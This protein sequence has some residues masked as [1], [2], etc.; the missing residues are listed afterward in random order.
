M[1]RGKSNTAYHFKIVKFD[2]N[3][4]IVAEIYFKTA[5]EIALELKVSRNTI[6]LHLKTP[7]R[8]HGKLKNIVIKKIN[9]PFILTTVNPRIAEIQ[10]NISIDNLEQITEN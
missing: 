5:G 6:Y 8:P 1:G 7:D 9:E 4:N 2:D 10:Q 3:N